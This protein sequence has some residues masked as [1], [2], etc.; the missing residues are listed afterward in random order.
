M[1][2]E[3]FNRH[4][5]ALKSQKLEK[6][7][8]MSSQYS[9]YVNEITLQQYHFDRSEKEVEILATITKD[10]VLEY[11]KLF[12]APNA[13]NRQSLSIHILANPES[14]EKVDEVAEEPAKPFQRIEDL[15]AFKLTKHLYPMAK[16]Y[17]N[18]VPKGA[19]SKL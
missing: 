9:H 10:Q 11:Y 19:K 4:K 8:R 12:L 6:P 13:P 18:I 5:E 17:I 14:I 16:S 15:T 7:K 1:N 3:E 2:D